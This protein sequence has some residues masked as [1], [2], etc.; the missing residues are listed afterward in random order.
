MKII[1][2]PLAIIG[3]IGLAA[4]T[5]PQIKNFLFKSL[6]IPSARITD[7]Y[8]LIGGI[9]LV[10]IGLFIVM[11]SSKMRRMK[12]GIEV[13]IYRGNQIVGYRKH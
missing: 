7:I 13:P 4:Y 3:V 6:N 5:V 2:Y 12:K 11:K 9:F 1:G 10:V 8:L